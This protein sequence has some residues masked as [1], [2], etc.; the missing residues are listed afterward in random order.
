M[1]VRIALVQPMANR[2]PNDERNIAD[3]WGYIEHAAA[4]QADFVLFP[5]SYPGP[6][7]MP[8]TFDPT[9]AMGE[10]ARRFGVHVVYGTLEPIDARERTAHNLVMLAYPDGRPQ[11]KYRRTH[12]PGP[13]LYTGGE[14][15]DFMYV[16]GND[17]P[18]FQTAHGAVGLAMCSEV[19]MPEVSRA[20]ALRGAEMIF[21]PAGVDKQRLWPTWRQLIW[22][23]A[24]ENLAVVAT[25]QNLFD[26]GQRG[27]AMLAAPEEIVF[28][29]TTAGLFV[30][31]VSL[32]RAREL[33]ALRDG[34]GSSMKCA[35][36][37]GVL[38]QWQRPELYDTFLPRPGGTRNRPQGDGPQREPSQRETPQRD[39]PQVT[40]P[41]AARGNRTRNLS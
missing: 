7:R 1:T 10:A 27:L 19:Y 31:S 37:A 26:P 14:Y 33:R 12:P 23:R 3:A 24:I 9:A 11:A 25:T 2:P 34:V 18:V 39:T 38:D 40:A 22:A 20:L 36:K 15:W 16:A 41:P 29:T 5:E 28:E 13:W 6:W 17:Y 4:Q 8:V 32:Q 21:M 30:V 35:A